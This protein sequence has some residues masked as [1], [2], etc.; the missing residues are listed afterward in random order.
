MKKYVFMFKCG[1]K[2][3]YVLTCSLVFRILNL[4]KILFPQNA[5]VIDNLNYSHTVRG[6]LP[7]TFSVLFRELYIIKLA[8]EIIIC[9]NVYSIMYLNSLSSFLR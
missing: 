5:I 8:L 3:L 4:E 2:L 6:P 9:L 7:S 1:V